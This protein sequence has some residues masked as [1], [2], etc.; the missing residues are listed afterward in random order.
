MIESL[1]ALR[2]HL[3][4]N[5]MLPDAHTV[6]VGKRGYDAQQFFTFMPIHTIVCADYGQDSDALADGRTLLSLENRQGE[7]H[8]WHH[9][10]EELF[11]SDFGEHVKAT[12]TESGPNVKIICYHSGAQIESFV[13]TTPG[14]YLFSV[15]EELRERLDNKLTL[16]PLLP[17]IGVTP[18]EGEIAALHRL[19]FDELAEKYGT[20]F[21]LQLPVGSAG[22][23]TAFID[24][25]ETFRHWHHAHRDS[26]VKIARFV[27]G[28][29]FSINAVVY[30]DQVICSQ[31]NVQIVGCPECV[32]LDTAY[33]GTDFTITKQYRPETIERIYD[34]TT[35]IGRW[36]STQ[37]YQG[38]YGLDLIVTPDEDVFVCELNARFTGEN[39]FIADYQAMRNM[40]PLSF[41]HVAAYANIEIS[42]DEIDA[43]NRALT[44]PLEGSCLTLHNRLNQPV[45]IDGDLKPGIYTF[46]DG[47][48]HFERPGLTLSQCR[49]PGE[50]CIMNAV[51]SKGALID[52]DTTLLRVQT[53]SSVLANDRRRLD[54]ETCALIDC[55][56]DNLRPTPS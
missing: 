30:H 10:T 25:A 22:S 13:D 29:S 9:I 4:D 8:E 37:S 46:S 1:S 45:R 17:T 42:T 27:D 26:K 56:Y 5:P 31:P 28:A 53:F 39:Q 2:S 11:Q 35:K 34:Y 3:A 51:P 41:F 15:R 18:I 38:M 23:G 20:P 24:S 54:S 7:R 50:I 52:A 33:C 55:I 43:Y 49:T 48:L 12:L 21:V 19:S 44:T 6:W 16:P 47:H 40:V 14:T 32:R 36:L